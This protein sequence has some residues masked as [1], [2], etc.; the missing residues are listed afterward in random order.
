VSGAILTKDF[1]KRSDEP[2]KPQHEMK[3]LEQLPPPLIEVMFKNEGENLIIGSV[4]AHFVKSCQ[5]WVEN[6]HGAILTFSNNLLM[7]NVFVSQPCLVT[8]TTRKLHSQVFFISFYVFFVLFLFLVLIYRCLSLFYVNP[9]KF[10]YF[11]IHSSSANSFR[12]EEEGVVNAAQHWQQKQAPG[13][14]NKQKGWPAGAVR[15]G[16]GPGGEKE[17]AEE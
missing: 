4:N 5:N 2:Y 8:Y 14:K 16:C 12:V 17:G 11:N 13:L 3:F 1:R 15:R 7:P 6:Y 10:Y 9:H